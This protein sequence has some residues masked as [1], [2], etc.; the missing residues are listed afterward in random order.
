MHLRRTNVVPVAPPASIP[1]RAATRCVAL[2]LLF[3][4]VSCGGQSS[5][6]NEQTTGNGGGAGGA[7]GQGATAGSAAAAAGSGAGGSGGSSAVAGSAGGAGVAGAGGVGGAGGIVDAG[8]ADTGGA[9]GVAGTGGSGGTGGLGGAGGTGGIADSGAGGTGG[10]ADSGA[11]ATPIHYG[12]TGQSCAGGLS[13]NAESCCTSINLPGGTFLQGRGTE[14]CG[15]V[16][17]KPADAGDGTGCP[18]DAIYC[19]SE[20]TPEFSSTV[21]AFALDKYLVTVGRIR[22][23]VSAYQSPS[24]SAP[25]EGSG[26][27]PAIP[28]SGWQ[29]A[30]NQDLP[31]SRQTFAARLKC[32]SGDVPFRTDTWTDAP[33]ENENKPINCITWYEAFA[34]CIWDGGRLATESEWEFAAAGGAEN[35][36]YPWGSAALDCTRASGGAL[37]VGERCGPDAGYGPTS[38]GLYPAGN[39]KWGHTDLAGNEGQWA[40][41]YYGPYSAAPKQNSASVGAGQKRVVRG[42]DF[43]LASR[44]AA[45]LGNYTF[46]G[47]ERQISI[48]VRCA[49]R[50]Q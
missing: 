28:G 29:S 41:D 40:L 6:S 20:E 48:G 25:P 11:D 37:A 17:C 38:V 26:A 19:S 46:S 43:G 45:R 3:A 12:I 14:D 44:S 21:S 42:G 8:G 5:D 27:N 1:A 23:F 30:W 50:A 4:I 49:R 2:G 33:G 15:V 35:R 7:G 34:F 9:G 10:I 22:K 47:Y 24:A 16:G 31:Y 13:C 39:G 36:L 32:F 18:N